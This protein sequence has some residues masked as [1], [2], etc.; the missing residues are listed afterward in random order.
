MLRTLDILIGGITVLLV[1]SMAVT[2]IT[3]V[4]N[5]L[6]GRKGGYLKAGLATLLQHLG[7]PAKSYA[8]EIADRILKHPMIA[9]A[10]GG[11]G[12]VIH[13]EEFTTLLLDLASGQGS[14]SL[15]SDALKALQNALQANGIS[16]PGKTLQNVR[17]MALQLEASSPGLASHA[18]SALAILR[19]GA[20]DFV[21]RIN[22]W[23]DQTIVR[24]SDRFT[25]HTHLVTL[26]IAVVVVIV[27]QLD[28]I[29]VLNRLSID[30]QFRDS[31][32]S[33]AAKQ[34]SNSTAQVDEKQYYGLLSTAGLITLPLNNN[35]VAQLRDSRKYPGMAISILLISLGAPFWYNILKDL[36]KLRS[37]MAQNDDQQREQRQSA[38]PP[39][40]AAGTA[41][42]A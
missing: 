33:S 14:A 20:S 29:A 12:E 2:V 38:Q 9:N 42:N 18:R 30:E 40:A 35:W 39:T 25:A 3:Q 17:A 10:R 15:S 26:G 7:I 41:A 16:D 6:L 22:F 36:L 8:Q 4:A 27:V 28:I 11:L 23:F 24:V 13:R 31:V 34:V 32:V 1:F 19:E 5:A 21:A 37:N